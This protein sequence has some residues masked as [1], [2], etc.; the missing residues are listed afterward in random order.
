MGVLIPRRYERRPFLAGATVHPRGGAPFRGELI[1]LGRG[2]AGLFSGRFLPVGQ[3]VEVVVA[4]GSAGLAVERRFAGRVA[5][6]RVGPEGNL[7]GIAFD[8]ELG[9]DDLRPLERRR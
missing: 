1:D 2:G 9:P 3:A 7:L 5:H 6:G 8:R 4:A